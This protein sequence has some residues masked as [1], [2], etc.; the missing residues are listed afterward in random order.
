LR[1]ACA[2]TLRGLAYYTGIVFEAFDTEDAL[3]SICGGGRYDRLLETLGGPPLPAAGFGMGDVVLGE[4]LNDKK[5]LPDL[6]IGIEDV[7][8]AFGDEERPAAI[9]L[10]ERLRRDGRRVELVLGSPRLKRVMADADKNGAARVWLIGPDEAA[11]GVA[12][13]RDLATGDQKEEKL[14]GP[15]PERA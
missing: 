12:T 3:R 7:V 1:I 13:V 14:A 15:K 6:P 9:R 2:S 8:F 4:L 10:A 5:L 11:R